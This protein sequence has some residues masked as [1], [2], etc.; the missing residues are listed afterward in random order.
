MAD[1][2]DLSISAS[3][4]DSTKQSYDGKGEMLDADELRLREMGMYHFVQG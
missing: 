4:V 3:V 1:A 2:K